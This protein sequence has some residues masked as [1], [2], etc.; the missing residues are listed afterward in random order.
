MNSIKNKSENEVQIQAILDK[1]IKVIH[2]KDLQGALDMYIE[3]VVTFDFKEPLLNK[4]KDAIKKRL[5]EWF[6][7]YKGAI[8]QEMK[9]LEIT[10]ADDIAFSH[11][12]T[13][14]YGI[15]GNNEQQDMWYRVTNGFK[16]INGTWLISHEHVSDPVDMETGK[17]MFELKP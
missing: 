2:D 13:R 15:S 5:Q 12:V 11:C 7:S 10:T 3:E 8:G 17:A 1:K 9:E 16:K 4:G 6:A 14:T